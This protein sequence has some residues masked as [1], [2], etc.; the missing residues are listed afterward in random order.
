MKKKITFFIIWFLAVAF[1]V[2]CFFPVVTY[3]ATNEPGRI[4]LKDRTWIVITD[5]SNQ[6]WYKKN[7]HTDLNSRFVK[8]LIQI[9]DANYYN[10]FWI[11]IISKIWAL[12]S[13]I[14]SWK[15]VSWWS[16]IT[17]QYIKNKFFPE[18]KRSYLQKTREAFLAFYYS[19]P[20]S[21]N[22]LWTFESRDYFKNKILNLYYHNAYFGNNL[23]WVWA[24]I[25]VYFW[26]NNLEDLTQEEIVL[27]ISLIHNPWITSL[28]EKKFREYFEKI[29]TKLWYD[30]E[31]K[32]FTLPKKEN[33]DIF[34]FVTN[35]LSSFWPENKTSIDYELQSFTKEIIQEVISDLK[36]KN[37][38]NSAVYAINPRTREILIYQW[39]KD[40]YSNEIDGEVNVI[41]SRRQPG[42]TMKPFLYLQAL[43]QWA[44]INSLLIDINSEYASFQEWRIYL[45]NNYSWK[46]YWLVRL[47]KA[48]WNS[49]NNASVRLAKE[50]WL[51]SVYDNYK[52][53]W[54]F[55]P[56][57]PEY[58]WYSLVLGNPSITLEEL[59]QSYSKLLPY[60]FKYNSETYQVENHWIDDIN[61]LL[62]YDILS[63]PD[64]RDISFWVN[65]VLNTSIPQAVKTW[66]SSN[67]RDNLVISYHPDF[68]IWVW[69]GNNDNSPMNWVTGITGAGYIWHQIIEKAIH[70]GYIKNYDSEKITWI[71]N[72][73]YC[74]DHDCFQLEY[75]LDKKEMIYTSRIRDQYYSKHDVIEELNASEIQRLE[76]LWFYVK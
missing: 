11:D 17:E 72:K 49:L 51:K 45:S 74:L 38:T 23:Y 16:T 70:L 55:L 41:T 28:E 31:R 37:V 59:V 13:N 75:S 19:L 76:E 9:E 43:E 35:N 60:K 46:E 6:Y 21:F 66:T 3:D 29:K 52:K 33:I 44:W 68:V 22:T 53:Y 18:A 40:F 4:Y 48:L 65:S 39:S 71:E 14:I 61:K 20:Y 2:Y 5:K 32:I 56:E 54:F 25:E 67:F 7:I 62:L 73:K 15:I 36:N 1:L 8:D 34:P 63:N 10:H 12:K 58:Y 42:S 26:K 64:N 57:S 47:K 24:A 30:F 69:V 50:L 27:L